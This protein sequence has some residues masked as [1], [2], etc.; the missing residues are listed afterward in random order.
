MSFVFVM[1]MAVESVYAA[2][3]KCSFFCQY[4]VSGD[5]S[6]PHEVVSLHLLVL[7]TPL[8]L[9]MVC[10]DAPVGTSLPKC[11]MCLSYY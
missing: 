10:S 3:R 9:V 8:V 11:S 7:L 6:V 2:L 5:C 4:Y 1:A